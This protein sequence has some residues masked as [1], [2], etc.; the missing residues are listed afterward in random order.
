MA[1]F[2]RSNLYFFT[3]PRTKSNNNSVT[4]RCGPRDNR[5]P[6][7]RGRVLSIEAIQAIQALKRAKKG[8]EAKITELVSQTLS[9]LLKNDL[10]ATLKE[11]LRQ[12]QCHPALEVFSAVR[13]EIWYRTD[14]S[15]YADIVSVLARNGMGEEIDRLIF[16]L[17]IGEW[18]PGPGDGRGLGRLIKALIDGARKESTV[19]IY[20][21]MKRSGW[22]RRTVADEYV[23][24][25]LSRGLR[26]LGEGAVADEADREFGRE[27]D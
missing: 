23:V 18:V 19:R 21:V 4:V 15:L 10:L 24:K 2:L 13:S 11:L 25:V 7:T 1:S 14:C 6:L 26:K 22:R 8:D 3:S 12:D 20:E 17:K 5:S 27:S 9:R 16:D